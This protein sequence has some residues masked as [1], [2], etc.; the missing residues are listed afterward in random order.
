[1]AYRSLCEIGAPDGPSR[2][3]DDLDAVAAITDALGLLAGLPE[4][5]FATARVLDAGSDAR[6]AL[7][8]LS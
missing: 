2:L 8:A 3:D 5:L 4:E 1:M 7:A 6:A